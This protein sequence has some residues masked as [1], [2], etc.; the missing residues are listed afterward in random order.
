MAVSK[1]RQRIEERL[2]A[3]ILPR[4]AETADQLEAFRLAVDAQEDY[5]SAAGLG[6]IPG[7]VSAISNDGVSMSFTGGAAGQD[8][9]SRETLCPAAWA[10]LRNAGLIAYSLPTAK[11]P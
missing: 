11:K 2:R 6:E 8:G 1:E 3:Y 10:Y 9:Y 7:N 4:K 5:E